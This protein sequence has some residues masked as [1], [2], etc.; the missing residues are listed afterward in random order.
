MAAAVV[1]MLL[2]ACGTRG[3][4]APNAPTAGIPMVT[5]SA[6]QIPPPATPVALPVPSATLPSLASP[7]VGPARVTVTAVD[8]NIFIRRGPDLAFNPVAVLTNGQSAVATAR[9]VLSRW[10]QI[11]V[12]GDTQKTGW[13]TLVTDYTSVTGDVQS[14][15]ES[16]TTVWPELAF[17]RNCTHDLM[18]ADPGGV[19]IPA[20]D[21]FPDNEVRINPGVYTIVDVDVD[22]YPQVLKVDIREG[23]AIDILIDGTGEK[24]KC[25]LP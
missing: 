21:Y 8:G 11:R 24:K 18:V 9:D 20:I 23:S 4:P 5:A 2:Q 1:P 10:L 3:A 13:V 15:P 14:L 6:T 7:T 12:P 19:T 17:L 16:Q 22:K 25:P